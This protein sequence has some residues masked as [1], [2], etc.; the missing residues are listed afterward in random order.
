MNL[1]KTLFDATHGVCAM[2][3]LFARIVVRY[4]GDFQGAQ[5]ELAPNN[6][7]PWPLPQLTFRESFGATSRP[8]CW[9]IRRS[10]M[11]WAF[12]APGQ[13]FDAGRRQRGARLAH[14]GRLGG[15]AH[16][17]CTQTV[18]QRQLWCRTGTTDRLRPGCHDHRFVPVAV[19][20]GRRSL[21]PRQQSSCHTLLDLRGKSRLSFTSPTA[22]P[23][24]SLCWDMLAIEAGAFYVMDRGYLDFSRLFALHQAGAFFVTRASVAWT[25]AECIRCRPTGVQASSATAH[26][27]ERILYLA[28]LPRA[29]AA[30]PFQRPGI[31][32][33]AGVPD[34]QY[35]FARPDHRRALQEPLASRTVLQVDQAASAHQAFHRQQRECSEDAGLVRRRHLRADRY[36]QKGFNL[37]PRS[38]L[39]Y[40][41]YRCLFSEKTP[42]FKPSQVMGWS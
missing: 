23:T 5:L 3:Q 19:S 14:L 9:P 37:M 24:R 27:A 11:G 36:C 32:Q 42:L 22:R 4:G 6:S 28:R 18:L 7:A 26:C 40:R 13:A 35:R 2:D 39:C 33:D 16:S 29:V 17:A 10:C 34:Q 8:V 15:L 31:W 38:T 30:Y 25:R 41:F 1:G 20:H 21:G 12:R